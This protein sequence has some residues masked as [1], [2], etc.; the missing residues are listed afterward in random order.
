V[1]TV[2]SKNNCP[3]CDRAKQ[4]LESKGVTYTEVNIEL[5]PES[6]Q[7]LLDKGLRSVPQIFYGYELIEGG[8]QG[9]TKKP[10]NF[11]NSLKG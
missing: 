9:L 11:F 5:D 6:R 10:E 4:L 7:M 8:F 2:Y 3:F 1:L